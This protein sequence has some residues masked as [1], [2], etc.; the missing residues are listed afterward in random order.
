MDGV[1]EE[2]IG[3][4]QVTGD[5]DGAIQGIGDIQATGDLVTDTTITH[6][7]TA[8]EVQLLIM[9]TEVMLITETIIQT[10]ATTQ[11]E[12]TAQTET[13]TEET[14]PQT[15]KMAFLTLEEVLL[16]EEEHTIRPAQLLQTEEEVRDKAI[17]TTIL[18]ED[19]AALQPEAMTV[20]ILQE[21]TL[22]AHRVR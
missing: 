8:E 15:D 2:V 19:Q 18:T 20:V 4:T 14:T 9:E 21:T 11:A 17:V 3:A 22:P 16:Q 10:E 7:T 13:T 12:I 5:Q 1:T 6:I